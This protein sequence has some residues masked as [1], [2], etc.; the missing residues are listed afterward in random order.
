VVDNVVITA[1]TVEP[2]PTVS[3]QEIQETQAPDGASPLLG[4]TVSTGGIVTAVASNGFFIQN[5]GGP[6]SGIFVF[7]TQ[8]VPA[9]GDSVTFTG[10]VTEFFG[11]T[12]LQNIVN[13][14][15][16]SQGNPEVVTTITAAQAN[17]ED[18][19][20]VL[21][22]ILAA[23]CTDPDIGN[24]QWAV[25]DGSATLSVDK[26]LFN[27]SPTQGAVYNV[28]GPTRYSFDVFRVMPRDAADIDVVTGVDEL[29]LATLTAYP[30]P[31]NDV[32][33]LTGVNGGTEYV[34]S[35]LAGRAVATGSLVNERSSI[36]TNA[37]PNGSY[38]LTL[39]RAGAVR[40]VKL[41]VQ[42]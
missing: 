37:L 8:N 6:W 33:W 7:S 14:S 24:N 21:V 19:E 34:L 30:N 20:G 3:I 11:M 9:R 25:N 4:E 5:G 1:E 41:V 22:R 29:A 40:S 23:T 17:T 39:R 15:V 42:H 35:D 13:F 12:Q 26:L 31:V 38:V 27:F 16:V 18:Y 2:P 10:S 32:L 28:T 36:H